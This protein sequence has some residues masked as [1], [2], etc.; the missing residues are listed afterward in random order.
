MIR[1]IIFFDFDGTIYSRNNNTV[2]DNLKQALKALKKQGHL[3]VLASD[4]PYSH[5]PDDIRALNFDGMVLSRGCH[6]I[7]NDENIKTHYLNEKN[8][9]KLCE[10]LD[11]EGIEYALYDLENTYLKSPE[12]ELYAFYLRNNLNI[13]KF[14]FMEDRRDILKNC[15][16]M[17][18][19]AGNEKEDE[20]VRNLAKDFKIYGSYYRKDIYE[21]GNDKSNGV[22][23]MLELLKG[24]YDRSVAFGDSKNDVN[25]LEL[26][27]VPFSMANGNEAAKEVAVAICKSVDEDGVYYKLKEIYDLD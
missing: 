15:I 14:V 8:L 1:D 6:L 27:D 9:E 21:E 10:D 12:G 23:E 5:I 18:F 24:Q 7:L 3:I 16:K 22:K 25:M 2:T 26:V 4:R 13:N 20:I 11:K 19:W 17:E